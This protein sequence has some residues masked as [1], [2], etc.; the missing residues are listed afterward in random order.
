MFSFVQNARETNMHSSRMRTARLLPVSPS[1]HCAGGVSALG[2]CLLWE[3][4]VCSHGRC[5]LQGD[6]CSGGGV[7]SHGRCMLQ[8]DICSGGWVSAQG[9]SALGCLLWGCVCSWEGVCSSGCLLWGCLLQ[10]G[11]V[12]ALGGVCSMGVCIP[13]CT[14]ADTPPVNRMTDRCKNI[15]TFANFVC[16]RNNLLDVMPRIIR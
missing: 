2:V 11:C 7:C 10:V 16:G 3:R 1:M 5:L 6:I 12:S 15:M 9:V 14:E 13:A 8:G 4:G